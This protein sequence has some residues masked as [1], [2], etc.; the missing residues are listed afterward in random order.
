MT[1][2]FEFTSCKYSFSLDTVNCGDKHG[3]KTH[4]AKQSSF[5]WRFV[6]FD[7]HLKKW[8][9]GIELTTKF[10]FKISN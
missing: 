5:T 9:L 3:N 8:L 7:L 1:W 4:A 10:Q 6:C 2:N